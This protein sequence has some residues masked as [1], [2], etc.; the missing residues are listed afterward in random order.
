MELATLLR[1]LVWHTRCISFDVTF[2]N[3]ETLLRNVLPQFFLHFPLLPL[4]FA[5]YD[6]FL[7]DDVELVITQDVAADFFVADV[8]SLLSR[9]FLEFIN[10]VLSLLT[11]F[12]IVFSSEEC[13]FVMSEL[14]VF[15]RLHL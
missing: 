4:E 9:S 6:F 7:H 1:L 11:Q 10:D 3:L 15:H 2:F 14:A 5:H 12:L 13:D 8:H